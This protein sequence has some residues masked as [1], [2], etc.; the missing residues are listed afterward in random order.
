[1]HRTVRE[2]NADIEDWVDHRSQDPKPYVWTETA[3]QM[4]DDHIRYCNTI[5]APGH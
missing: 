3:D 1:M 5:N 2:R 4:L